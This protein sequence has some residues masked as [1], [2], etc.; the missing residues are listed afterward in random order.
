MIGKTMETLKEYPNFKREL[1]YGSDSGF[2]CVIRHRDDQET[3]MVLTIMLFDVPIPAPSGVITWPIGS[4][5]A[6]R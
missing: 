6:T 3:E 2:R 5:T 4:D 1:P